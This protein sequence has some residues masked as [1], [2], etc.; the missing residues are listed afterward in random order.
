MDETTDGG[1]GRERL[2]LRSPTGP[3]SDLSGGPTAG[4]AHCYRICWSDHD[5]PWY[6]SGDGSGSFDLT[7]GEHGT[8]YWADDP[9][10]AIRERLGPDFDAD[11]PPPK[12]WS[13]EQ[14][15][16]QG[17]C[18]TE[19]VDWNI[20]DLEDPQW[21]R[22]ITNELFSVDNYTV[23]NEWA[24]H[25]FGAGFKGLKHPPRH[26]TG[27][28]RSISLFGPTGAQTEDVRIPTVASTELASFIPAFESATNIVFAD[29]PTGIEDLFAV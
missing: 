6:F 20:A 25:F 11:Y 28:G 10:V 29:E 21:G 26:L 16:W 5:A 15:M 4:A 18:V 23:S 2:A 22:W 27:Q 9:N 17:S 3:P 14:L 19:C 12:S 24:S 8:C 1:A 7:D 13:H